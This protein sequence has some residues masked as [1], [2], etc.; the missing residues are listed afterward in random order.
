MVRIEIPNIRIQSHIRAGAP[1][2]PTVAPVALMAANPAPALGI[3]GIV[4][5]YTSRAFP[6]PNRRG[7]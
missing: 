6:N 3:L 4:D 1:M 5:I 7:N 2:M